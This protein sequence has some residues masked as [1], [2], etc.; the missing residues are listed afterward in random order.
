MDNI[1]PL[2]LVEADL[3]MAFFDCFGGLSIAIEV[4]IGALFF[5]GNQ[6]PRDFDSFEDVD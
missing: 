4:E 6:F 2:V 1:V 3:V 5:S